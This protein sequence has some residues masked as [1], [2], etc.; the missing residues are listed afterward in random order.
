MQFHF[1]EKCFCFRY[2]N[3]LALLPQVK[4]HWHHELSVHL[5]L[6]VQLH[7]SFHLCLKVQ[8][9]HCTSKEVAGIT[10][11]F[12]TAQ[13]S[14]GHIQYYNIY[15]K[16]NFHRRRGG[17]RGDDD[18]VGFIREMA[19]IDERRA[20]REESGEEDACVFR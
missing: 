11:H 15:M 6:G 13:K 10:K 14:S 4:S 20:E 19:I 12:A 8:L 3:W 17:N 9:H 16:L 2:N 1:A 18:D 7:H 5:N